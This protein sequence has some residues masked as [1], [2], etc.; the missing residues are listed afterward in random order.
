MKPFLLLSTRV[1]DHAAAGEYAAFARYAG[2]TPERL[3]HIR[4]E[5]GPLPALDL[6]QFAGIFVGGSPFNSSDP[7]DRKSEVQRRVETELAALL[8]E[9]VDRD[10]PFFGACYGVGTLG[11]HQGAVIDS[12]FAEQVGAVP[13]TLTA[14]GREDPL[15]AGIPATF[16]ALVGHKEACRS[17]PDHVTLL[18][19]SSTCPIQMFRVKQNL[20]ATQFH[21]ELDVAGITLRIRTYRHSGYFPPDDAD[22]V[23]ARVQDAQVGVP[24]QILGNFTRRYGG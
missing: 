23:I 22:E 21:P 7:V 19:S 18:A 16:D 10:F 3:R 13:I 4:M 20:Y 11:V 2:L 14:A 15:L 6:D 9:V 24:P 5:A 8:D 12:T 17:L 1:D